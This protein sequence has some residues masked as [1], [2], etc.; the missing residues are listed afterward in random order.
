MKTIEN[1]LIKKIKGI[2][3][4][5]IAIGC[6][7]PILDALGKNNG[8]HTCY[9]LNNTSRISGKYKSSG[10]MKSV[11]IKK[12]KRK[13]KKKR[14]NVMIVDSLDVIEFSKR[15]VPSSV[16]IAKE[17]IYVYAKASD[18]KTEEM[19]LKYHRYQAPVEEIKLQDGIIYR[20][21]CTNTKQSRISDFG[22]LIKDTIDRV[23]DLVG[24]YLIN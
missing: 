15:F 23:I 11:N 4:Q 18:E 8:I 17:T 10:F 16:Y 22:Y 5:V 24:D 3:G 19:I 6:T 13:F 9:V 1:Y 21:D 12:F 20:I 2:R 7:D 14:T